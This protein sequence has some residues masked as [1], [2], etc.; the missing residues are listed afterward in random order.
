MAKK[1]D[2]QKNRVPRDGHE[3]SPEK[4]SMIGP[5]GYRYETV[6][7]PQSFRDVFRYLKELFGG[8]FYRLFYIISLVWKTGPWILFALFS[9]SLLVGLLPVL[10]SLVYKDVINELQIIV[11]AMSA[12]EATGDFL[13]SPVVFLLVFFFLF[14]ILS[15][16][17][18]R[19][20]A[21]VTRIAGELVVR[22]VKVE[23]MKKAKEIDL[24]AYDLPVPSFT[25]S[26]RMPTGKRVFVP[27]ISLPLRF[28]WSAPLSVFSAT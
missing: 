3:K 5:G 6:A 17:I 26:L 12:G 23:M 28:L 9:I 19:I 1:N 11:T 20:E 4:G 25:R 27:F 22:H 15:R 21:S 14:R 18:G 13:Q 7:K 16:I 24:A 2:M 10:G 8:F